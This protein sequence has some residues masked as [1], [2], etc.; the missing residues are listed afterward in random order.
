M[1]Y[2]DRMAVDSD[3]PADLREVLDYEAGV[4]LMASSR[5]SQL[6]TL[7]DQ[8]LDDARSRFEKFLAE[9]PR[10]ELASQAAVQLANLLVERGRIRAERAGRPS[11]LPAQ[12]EKLLAEARGFYGEAHAAFDRARQRYEA[13]LKR[14]G[15]TAPEGQLSDNQPQQRQLQSDLLRARLYLATAIYEIGMTYPPGDPQRKAKLTEAA[16][17]YGALYEEFAV[18]ASEPLLAGL[19]ARLWQGQCYRELGKTKKAASI[20]E[21]LLN[22][23]DDSP[24]AHELL[25]QT[26][27]QMMKT[28]VGP[29]AKKCAAAI[30]VYHRWETAAR[31]ADETSAEGLAIGYLAAEAHLQQ[32]RS[33][34]RG[35]PKR[36]KLLA[37]ARRLFRSVGRLPG[38]H[39]AEA[40]AK[41]LH[42][43][44]GNS[45]DQ[46]EEPADFASARDRADA[47]KDRMQAAELQEEPQ[48][49]AHKPVSP[50]QRAEEIAQ[51]R[52][53][54]IRYYRRALALATDKTPIDDLNLARYYLAYLYWTGHERY[55][56]AV[57]GEFLA[58]RYPESAVAPQAATIALV[59]YAEL[60]NQS[61]SG[62][63]KD[64]AREHMMA[65]ADHIARRWPRDSAAGD[66]W[67]T[68]V[69]T[70]VADGNLKVA[71]D[72]LGKIPADSPR[73]G[74]AEVMVGRAL[75]SRWASDVRRDEA[76]RPDRATLNNTLAEA[77]RLL[78]SGL[79]RMSTE[80]QVDA[81][82]IAAVH[83]L[84]QI[85]LQQNQ[86]EDAVKLL[87][88]PAIGAL[89]LVR[90]NHPAATRQGYDVE[91]YKTA[92]RAYVAA[93]Q[94]DKAEAVMDALEERVA[95]A[96]DA[97][98]GARLTEIYLGL[99]RELQDML[100][101]LQRQNRTEELAAISR[102]FELFLTRIAQRRQGNTFASLA[103]VAGTLTDLGER[104]DSGAGELPSEARKHYEQAAVV[105]NKILIRCGK[106]P[107]F[108]PSDASI[109]SVK[110][111]S[112]HVLRRLGRFED[113]MNRLVD[114]LRRRNRM[115]DAQIEAARAY[116]DW[117]AATGDAQK[118]LDAIRGGYPA[119][120]KDGSRVNVVWGWGKLASLTLQSQSRPETF[121]E[122]RYNLARCRFEYAMSL[123]GEAQKNML[124]LAE[125]DIAVTQLLSPT[126][127]GTQ[128]CRDYDQLLQKIQD[129]QGKEPVGLGTKPLS[130]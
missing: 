127:G 36:K 88:A 98:A 122:A 61:P 1:I 85:Y 40:K 78:A 41:L 111:R 23:P 25:R 83:A 62:A 101:A 97:Q 80:G 95:R 33:L 49:A 16:K 15:G 37:A 21:E 17:D 112:A 20:F 106:D 59:A 45:S 75:W 24:A 129:A 67:I 89:T 31:G 3:C 13:A 130:E 71:T 102:G 84:A 9:H 87:D 46:P 7:R 6:S 94:L 70:A 58:R 55:D 86:P 66:A 81:P 47:A 128:R 43:L 42:P 19:Y 90:A 93:K 65:V 108:A 113:A 118:Y 82:L 51:S 54:A 52:A 39:Q 119:R 76:S 57:L 124:A 63:A 18:R 69:H 114:V 34:D 91:I 50:Q 2:L 32:A 68:L 74:E 120:R 28:L 110:V 53:E 116:Q 60:Y 123:P 10:H 109:D 99:S 126:L 105:Y 64:F 5:T 104:F 38:D 96:T 103:W 117:A 26:V 121:H 125:K 100:S 12:K 72:Y 4:T 92:L 44:L 8:T 14:A 22:Q 30:E 35:D 79:K 73:R 11:L 77:Q 29:S 48:D 27:L 107:R 56:A 115:V